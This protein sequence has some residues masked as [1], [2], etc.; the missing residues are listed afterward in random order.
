MKRITVLLL[1]C[2][3]TVGM[4]I[5]GTAVMA[6]ETDEQL[7]SAEND[8]QIL[9]EEYVPVSAAAAGSDEMSFNGAEKFDNCTETA[10]Y[11]VCLEPGDR[12]VIDGNILFNGEVLTNREYYW[13]G[14]VLGAKTGTGCYEESS[15]DIDPIVSRS[16]EDGKLC[17]TAVGPGV[18]FLPVNSKDGVG[19]KEMNSYGFNLW[20]DVQ[21][22]IKNAEVSGV[23]NAE[24][25]GSAVKPSPVVKYDGN[26]LKKGTDY[27]VSYTDSEGN[28]VASPKNAGKYYVVITGQGSYKGTKK[29]AF[30]ITAKAV[31]PA[32]S[33]SVSSCTWN[34]KA[35]KPKAAVTDGSVTF[36]SSD[37]TVSYKNN[38]DVGKASVTV[39]MKGNYSGSKTV[40]FT[41]KPQGTVINRL[42]PRAEAFTAGWEKQDTPM[43][44]SYITGY[45]IQLASDKAFTKNKKTVTVSDYSKTGKKIT[46]LTGG[47]KYFVRIRTYMK[48]GTKNYYSSWSAAQTVTTKK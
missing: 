44:S 3:L 25:S 20:I 19:G 47:S 40:Y 16:F 46:G 17:L 15:G 48:V 22:P 39:K 35:K 45:Q 4:L 41:I 36:A 13:V 34:G 12:I 18:V 1:T 2:L 31:T 21:L 24:Y 43:S 42:T 38:T 6:D 27:T 32:V 28:D 11:L 23:E 5:P 33:L 8:G 37:Y 26:K 14:P 7:I 30:R 29:T 9:Q 10:A